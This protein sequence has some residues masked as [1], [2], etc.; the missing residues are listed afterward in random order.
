MMLL[1][2]GAGEYTIS[3]GFPKDANIDGTVIQKIVENSI[4]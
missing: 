4:H 2:G 3:V 1:D